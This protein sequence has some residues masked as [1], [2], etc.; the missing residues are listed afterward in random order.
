[1]PA[2][3]TLIPAYGRDYKSAKEVRADLNAGKDFQLQP[4]GQHCSLRD[5][6]AG[7]QLICRY[8]SLR[9][10][11]VVKVTE[12]EGACHAAAA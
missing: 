4:S 5:F 2:T 3:F 11:C 9:Q 10:L 1:M 7:T 8:R 6:P 12:I